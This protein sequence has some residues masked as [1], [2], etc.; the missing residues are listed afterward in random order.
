MLFDELDYRDANVKD[1]SV[2]ICERLE[3]NHFM[4]KWHYSGSIN[5][6][7][8]DYC[9][10]LMYDREIIGAGIF[11]K[12]A[13]HGQWKRFGECEDDVIELRRL[14]CID[15]TPRN[16]ESYFIG[17]MLKWLI[18][19]TTIKVVVSYADAEHGHEGTIYK[20]SNFQ[21]IDFKKGARVIIHNGKSFH[22]KSI[23]TKYKDGLKPFAQR[24]VNALESGEAYYK[25]T[26]GKFCYIYNL[27][28][29]RTS[30]KV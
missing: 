19:N 24:L 3:I 12:M 22:D 18:K 16:T 30:D 10:K 1:F 27:T 25:T 7:I 23:R 9:F 11:G 13:M 29:K 2:S 28:E 4:E 6:V 20:A 8:A 14:C 5:G 21:L 15:N 17:K 26:K